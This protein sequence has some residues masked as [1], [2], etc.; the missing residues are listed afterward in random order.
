MSDLSFEN[1]F[2][3]RMPEYFNIHVIPL[4]QI[5]FEGNVVYEVLFEIDIC[6]V[7]RAEAS[8]N[9]D[10]HPIVKQ[11]FSRPIRIIGAGIHSR[12]IGVGI[13]IERQIDTFQV[14]LSPL[15]QFFCKNAL[16]GLPNKSDF[17]VDVPGPVYVL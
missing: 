7:V 15:V 5:I 11:T 8:A 3:S 17:V 13:N 6:V 1:T 12:S 16:S 2:I 10:F 9:D 14:I 4:I